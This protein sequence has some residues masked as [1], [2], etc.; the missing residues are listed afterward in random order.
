M[1]RTKPL[2]VTILTIFPRIVDAYLGESLLGKA[3][4]NNLLEV[5]TVDLREYATGPH[6]QVDA[7]PFGGG[8]GMV[9]K[10]EPIHK[11]VAAAVKGGKKT[12]IILPSTRGKVFDQSVAR[13]LSSY[14]HLVFICGR[15]EGVDERVAEHVADEE[16][17]L[18]AYV[19]AGGELPALVITE[20]VARLRKG[21]MHTYESL[22]DVK[23]SYPTYTR[24]EMFKP[25]GMKKAWSVPAVLM[26]GDHQEIEAWRRAFNKSGKG[27][28]GEAAR[29]K[30]S[31]PRSGPRSRS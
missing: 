16:V 11:A 4:K 26:S 23:G 18:G 22:E 13:R 3:Q 24:P 10:V 6:R 17:S 27:R 30:K 15:Y 8:P 20:A 12:R 5:N 19:L 25:R 1:A 31:P 29:S 21:F 7:P 9:M 28:D 2:R 14:D